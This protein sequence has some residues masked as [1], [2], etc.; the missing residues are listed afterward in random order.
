MYFKP[1]VQ[2]YNLSI[3]TFKNKVLSDP[4]LDAFLEDNHLSILSLRI[5]MIERYFHDNFF[6][7]DDNQLKAIWVEPEDILFIAHHPEYIPSPLKFYPVSPDIITEEKFERG[8]FRGA[9]IYNKV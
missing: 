8:S 2:H 7:K 9:K 1:N 5:W 6:D 3:E 4:I